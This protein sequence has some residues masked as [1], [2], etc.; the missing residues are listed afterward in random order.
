MTTSRTFKEAVS[1]PN[2][3]YVR[4]ARFAFTCVST[5]INVHNLKMM[6]QWWTCWLHKLTIMSSCKYT[7]FVNL[8][9]L[10]GNLFFPD[11]LLSFLNIE[12]I[13]NIQNVGYGVYK[14]FIHTLNPIVPF[15]LN[16]YIIIVYLCTLYNIEDET[17]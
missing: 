5:M 11:K 1:E 15:F 13:K 8:W 17:P 4:F 2:E 6:C 14:W 3:C 16:R 7:F 10:H 12:L 9:K